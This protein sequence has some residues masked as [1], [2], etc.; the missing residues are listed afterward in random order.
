MQEGEKDEL[1]V[2]MASENEPSEAKAIK[3]DHIMAE[4]IALN[5]E[6]RKLI[7]IIGFIGINIEELKVKSGLDDFMYRYHMDLLLKE[8]FL[9][10]EEGKYH[11]TDKGIMIHESGINIKEPKK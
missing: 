11:L 3:M 5:Y 7:R 1:E 8:G 6:R 9:K 4:K 2:Y 10:V